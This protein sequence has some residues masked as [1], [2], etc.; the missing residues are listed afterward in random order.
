MTT[1]IEESVLIPQ[2]P[3]AVWP[4]LADPLAWRRWIEVLDIAESNPPGPLKTGS[5]VRIVGNKGPAIDARAVNVVDGQQIDLEA[6]GLPFD[7]EARIEF[8]VAADGSGTRVSMA[9]STELSGMMIFAEKMVMSKGSAA[10]SRWLARLSEIAC[11][12]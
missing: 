6:S 3:H 8:R 4:L 1:R 7:L 12:P 2:K 11:Q 5:G 9:M 10:L